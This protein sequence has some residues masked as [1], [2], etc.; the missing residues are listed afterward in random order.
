[1][2]PN[3]T[4]RRF[5]LNSNHRR[6]G[7]DTKMLLLPDAASFWDVFDVW[8]VDRKDVAKAWEAPFPFENYCLKT[9]KRSKTWIQ[10]GTFCSYDNDGYHSFHARARREVL[11]LVRDNM[12]AAG[13]G[14]RITWKMVMRKAKHGGRDF[15]LIIAMNSAI[16]GSRWVAIVDASTLPDFAAWPGGCC[17][18]PSDD[19]D[20]E[21]WTCGRRFWAEGTEMNCQTCEVK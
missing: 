8:T 5:C 10:I 15:V 11:D 16:I 6:G 21:C 14:D 4:L 18:S 1:M 20:T 9:G 12:L 13:V 17:Y 19:G 3:E 7:C 2:D